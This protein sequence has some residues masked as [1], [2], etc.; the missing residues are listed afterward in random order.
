MIIDINTTLIYANVHVGLQV[1]D[2]MGIQLSLIS[3]STRH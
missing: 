2:L 1:N 3:T